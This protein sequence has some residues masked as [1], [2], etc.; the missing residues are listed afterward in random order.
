MYKR[1]EYN[2][3]NDIF[4]PGVDAS[5]FKEYID[6]GVRLF[7]SMG[8][9]MFPKYLISYSLSEIG[10]MAFM[11]RYS[12]DRKKAWEDYVT[13]CKAGGSKP[14]VELLEIAGLEVP[15]K[16]G[17]VGRATKYIRELL[18]EMCK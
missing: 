7:K 9:Y 4:D 5:M 12:E 11:Q 14:Y 8:V 2:R 6:G 18:E 15:F 17:A 10:A 16:E 1:Q 3:L 13:F